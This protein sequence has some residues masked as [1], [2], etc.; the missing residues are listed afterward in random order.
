MLD[1]VNSFKYLGVYLDPTLSWKDHLTH[2]R[3]SVNRKIG[4]LYRTRSF[5]KGDTLNTIYQSVVLPS[6]EYCDVV[7]GNAAKQYLCKLTKLQN[8]AGKTILNVDRLFPTKSM[9]DCLGWK[10]LDSRREAHLNIMVYKCVTAKSPLYLCNNFRKVSDNTSY[11]T[12]GSTQGNLI[13]PNFKNGSG[14]RTFR[15]RGAVSWNKLPAA[16]KNPIPLTAN[17][18]KCALKFHC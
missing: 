18:F 13:P 2:V 4:L 16:C 12:R 9:L 7:W 11:Q 14:K 10:T 15:Y 1:Q 6:L 17:Q 5:L 3:N 8:R